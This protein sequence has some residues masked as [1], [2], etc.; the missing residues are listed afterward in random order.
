MMS[1][2]KAAKKSAAKV[3]QKAAKK[4]AK[5]T[6]KGHGHDL[7]RAY[8]HMHRVLLLH[9]GLPDDALRQVD[10]LTSLAQGMLQSEQNKAA[11]D[12]LRAA[13]HVSF[14]ALAPDAADQQV[15]DTLHLAV[16]EEFTRLTERAAMHW[17]ERGADSP[18][19]V[20]SI[21][22]GLL[23]S[24]KAAMKAGALPRALEYA[25]GAEALAHVEGG[26]ARLTSPGTT[27][28]RLLR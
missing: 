4:V 8:E 12:L 13:E 3:A 7:R 5:K 23:T 11:A 1:P 24:A 26:P 20:S 10:T 21:Y 15:S 28:D 19:G 27:V 17:E 22:R 2:K 25:R 18:R 6:T 14:G 16:A 9:R